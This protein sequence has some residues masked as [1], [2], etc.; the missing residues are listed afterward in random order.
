MPVADALTTLRRIVAS[1]RPAEGGA[2]EP[3]DEGTWQMH[4]PL[5][6]AEGPPRGFWLTVDGAEPTNEGGCASPRMLL[7]VL[8]S[9]R[10]RSIPSQ[11]LIAARA[12]EDWR[13]LRDALTMQPSAWDYGFSGIAT[14]EMGASSI[15]P[16]L[17]LAADA[18]T[19]YVM[20]IPLFVEVDP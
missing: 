15:A 9:V 12:L 3:L 7:H 14:V 8:L 4:G 20:N 19:H 5:G 18:F 17:T 11:H 16:G 6:A 13:R 2:F 1:V 10:Y